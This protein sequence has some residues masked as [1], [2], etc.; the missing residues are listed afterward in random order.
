MGTDESER[1]PGDTSLREFYWLFT[2]ANFSSR[3][4]DLSPLV[5]ILDE[6]WVSILDFDAARVLLDDLLADC[7]LFE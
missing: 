3:D 7:I 2:S 5:E 1:P 4:N 6:F